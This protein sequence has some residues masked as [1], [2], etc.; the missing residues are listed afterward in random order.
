MNR[1]HQNG[2]RIALEAK[3]LQNGI[4][5]D[6]KQ[7]AIHDGPGIRTTVFLKG[8]PLHCHWCHNPEGIQM[9]PQINYQ[10]QRCIGC[11]ECLDACPEKALSL[12][13]AGITTEQQRCRSCGLCAEACPSEARERIGRILSSEQLLELVKKD[14]PFYEA[15]GGGVTFSGGEPL[16]QAEF[17]IECLKLCAGNGIHCAVDTSGFAAPEVLER[18]ARETRLFLYDLKIM[19]SKKHERFTGKSNQQILANLKYLARSNVPVVIRMPLIPGINDDQENIDLLARF[20]RTLPKTYHVHILPYHEGQENKYRRLNMVLQTKNIP[21]PDP[22][23]L[24]RVKN[25]MENLGL[26]VQIG[27]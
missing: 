23:A 6:V 5:F 8:C 13:D 14:I 17:L 15:S 12:T 3:S 20:I 1:W 22:K 25:R 19:D 11:G 27:G 21:M 26:R 9:K 7:Y 18:V 10:R 2:I 24:F 4:I 16:R